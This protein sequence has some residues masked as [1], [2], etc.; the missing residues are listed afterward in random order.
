MH[1]YIHTNIHTCTQVPE[2]SIEQTVEIL[3][4]LRERYEDHHNVTYDSEAIE[5]AAKLAERY[6]PDRFLPDKAI[7]L[8]DEAGAIVQI[9]EFDSGMAGRPRAEWPAVSK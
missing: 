8:M 4:T 5:A 7:D 1:T 6:L 3:S 9:D 2:P